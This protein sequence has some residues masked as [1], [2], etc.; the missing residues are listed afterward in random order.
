MKSMIVLFLCIVITSI[1]C[2]SHAEKK[3]KSEVPDHWESLTDLEGKWIEI[4]RDSIGYFLY[5]PCD[6]QTPNIIVSNDF[7]TLNHQIEEPTLL[8]IDKISI[9][10]DSITINTNS[11]I[12]TAEFI[13]KIVDPNAD[14][15]LFKWNYPKYQNKGKQ[16][17]AKASAVKKLRNIKN[18]CDTEKVPDHQFL[19][20]EYN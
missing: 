3:G 12:L 13:F 5:Q 1:S 6:G 2:I 17:I 9:T 14:H 18:P 19:P 20:I 8:P 10:K 7:I 15:I 4:E 11:E 16:V